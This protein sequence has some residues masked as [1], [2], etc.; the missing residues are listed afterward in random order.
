MVDHRKE[1]LIRV[2]TEILNV[3]RSEQWPQRVS[4]FKDP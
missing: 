1:G 4:D 3:E 2:G